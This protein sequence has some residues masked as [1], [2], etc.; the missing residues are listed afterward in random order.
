M[1]LTRY[2]RRLG[3]DAAPCRGG[4]S[5]K[6]KVKLGSKAFAINAGKTS[7]VKIRL[8]AKNLAKLK[9]A[10]KI[11]ATATAKFSSGGGKTVTAKVTILAPKKS[12]A[13]HAALR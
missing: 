6:A 2:Q 1:T 11:V 12:P 13:V 8:S 4:L 9:K 5:L 3:A 10:K 7:A